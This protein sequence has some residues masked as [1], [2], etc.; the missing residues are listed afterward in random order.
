ML[1]R[2]ANK[3]F[4]TGRYL[5]RSEDSSKL[6]ISSSNL[7]L[8]LPEKSQ[9]KWEILLSI[10]DYDSLFDALEKE[11]SEYNIIKFLISD[12]LN[13]N[14]ILRNI[15]MMRENIRTT[16]DALPYESWEYVNELYHFANDH[17]HNAH[18]RKN[19]YLFFKL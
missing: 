6:L 14:S 5:E 15:S 2:V 8:D 16:R 12:S 11:R 4:W 3:L 13:L 7:I 19:R 9:V 17:A 18:N 10:F 1:S